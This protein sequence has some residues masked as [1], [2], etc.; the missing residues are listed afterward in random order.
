MHR[1]FVAFLLEAILSVPGFAQCVSEPAPTDPAHP[2][3]AVAEAHV[4]DAAEPASS[5]AIHRL[6]H[7]RPSSLPM[8]YAGATALQSYDTALTLGVIGNGVA[9]E[10]NPLMKSVV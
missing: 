6:K 7:T 5:Y 10:T 1:L 8:L 4:V 9:R 3:A 2:P